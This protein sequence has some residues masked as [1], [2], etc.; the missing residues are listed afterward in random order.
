MATAPDNT[1]AVAPLQAGTQLCRQHAA[2]GPHQLLPEVHL[3]GSLQGPVQLIH[4]PL[5]SSVHL[6]LGP[7]T[8]ALAPEELLSPTQGQRLHQGERQGPLQRSLLLLGCL[9]PRLQGPV[10]RQLQLSLL[11]Q[12]PRLSGAGG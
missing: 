9:A 11:L 6:Q 1:H 7:A 8:W 3:Q 5:K 4:I 10:E 12:P 2:R